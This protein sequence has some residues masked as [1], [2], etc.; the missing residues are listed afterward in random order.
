MY[1]QNSTS[2]GLFGSSNYRWMLQKE[3]IAAC[4]MKAA[5]KHNKASDLRCKIRKKRK[6]YNVNFPFDTQNIYYHIICHDRGFGLNVLLTNWVARS[7]VQHKKK[8]FHD[9]TRKIFH[10]SLSF[11]I[12]MI[13]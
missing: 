2:P 4:S 9:F 1:R 5:G 12:N 10:A 3:E 13:F 7:S 11:T 6:Y 8:V